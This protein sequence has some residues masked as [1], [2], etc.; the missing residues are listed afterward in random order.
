VA[1]GA[2][3]FGVVGGEDFDG[4]AHFEEAGADAAAEA[5][6]E[7]R[8][9]RVRLGLDRIRAACLRQKGVPGVKRYC[10]VKIRYC[11]SLPSG[12]SRVISSMDCFSNLIW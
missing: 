7:R 11:S 12:I 4:A 9:H 2:D 6:G 5:A 10:P 1:G 8:F 3:F